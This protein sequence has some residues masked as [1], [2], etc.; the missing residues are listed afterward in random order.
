M[1]PGGITN[2]A[3]QGNRV[4]PPDAASALLGHSPGGGSN[5]L[6]PGYTWSHDDTS[7]PAGL[8][9]FEQDRARLGGMLQ[10]Q[11]P[12]ASK[13]WGG[14][15]S[16]LQARASGQGP[17]VA[18][19]QYQQAMGN[20]NNQL[21]GMAHGGGSPAAFRQAA[22]EQGRTGQGLAQ[23]SALARTQEMQAAQG[24]LQ[25]A[26]GTRDTI[27]STAYQ[28]ILQQQLGLSSQSVNAHLGLQNAN[29]QAAAANYQ[30]A[31]TGLT[32]LATV[33]KARNGGN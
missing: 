16:Q 10:G 18:Q 6:P 12:F 27:N 21:S 8:P 22:I 13:D 2:G 1:P 29:N 28:N 9:Y 24:S 14:L 4:P 19:M 33:I 3:D 17:S 11:S 32:A 30:A 26:L 23:G 5:G 31:G 20:A 15:I 7:A 25:G